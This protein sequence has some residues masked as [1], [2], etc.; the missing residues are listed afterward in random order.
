MSSLEDVERFMDIIKNKRIHNPT[1]K[2]L[3]DPLDGA[4]F[5]INI[6]GWARIGIHRAADIELPPVE[7]LKMEYGIVNNG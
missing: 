1:Y 6:P 2:P 3:N 4:G 7:E 5:S